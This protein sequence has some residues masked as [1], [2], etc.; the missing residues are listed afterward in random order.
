MHLQGTNT[1]IIGTGLERILIDTGEGKPEWARMVIDQVKKHHFEITMVLLTHWHSDH[2][3]G[4]PDLLRAYPHLK[5]CIYKCD[6]D[7]NQQPIFDGQIFT[8]GGASIRAV[9]TPGH[10]GDHMC[11]ALE[12]E[13]SLFT[14]DNVLGHGA[15]VIEDL[16]QY[17]QSL[18]TMLSQNCNTGYPGH[19]AMIQTL[20]LKLQQEIRRQQRREQQVLHALDRIQEVKPGVISTRHGATVSEIGEEAFGKLSGPFFAD[21]IEPLVMD[22][23]LKLEKEQR[24]GF[25]SRQGI[26][27]W[28]L[29]HDG[30][31]NCVTTT[32]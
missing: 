16:G 7:T 25:A 3:D 2:T 18:Q 20:S 10:A 14:G 27:H 1:Y 6:P 21:V 26:Q 17:T 4:V 24:V 11:F 15:T 30:I 12:E 28:F 22:I 23:L 19:G 13:N 31:L 32:G 9:F 8:V 5:G 29:L